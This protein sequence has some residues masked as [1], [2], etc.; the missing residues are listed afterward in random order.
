MNGRL[1]A[2]ADIIGP[3][4]PPASSAAAHGPARAIIVTLTLVML[5]MIVLWMRT[6]RSRRTRRRLRRLRHDYRSGR[7][8]GREMAYQVAQEMA[9][10]FGV[11]QVR[12]GEV[13]AALGPADHA[14]W[15]ELVTRLDALRYRPDAVVDRDETARLV[16]WVRT[17]IG[18]RR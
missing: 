2:L 5:T 13:P 14:R 4:A 16:G 6:R 11:R 17:R 18:K 9:S 7:L 10:A 1:G 8:A 12:A 15:V 3:T